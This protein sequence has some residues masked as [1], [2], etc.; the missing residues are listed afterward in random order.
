MLLKLFKDFCATAVAG[1]L[2]GSVSAATSVYDSQ[3]AFD[4]GFTQSGS[5]IGFDDPDVFGGF[6][7]LPDPFVVGDVSFDDTSGRALSA[8][9]RTPNDFLIYS[10]FGGDHLIEIGFGSGVSAV[11]FEF[12]SIVGASSSANFTLYSSSG[13]IGEYTRPANF[14]FTFIGFTSDTDL[15]TRIDFRVIGDFEA[16]DNVRIGSFAA[17]VPL[18]ATGLMLIAAVAGLAGL[19]RW[20][21]PDLTAI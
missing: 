13:A 3:A 14:S 21:K 20:K 12:A 18:P 5:T 8:S 10:L 17:P 19:R 4:A 16:L 11:S 6:P 2:A 7:S 1:L 15:I 9:S